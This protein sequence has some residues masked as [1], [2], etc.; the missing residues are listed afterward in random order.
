MTILHDDNIADIKADDTKLK[1]A[2]EVD[3]KKIE[4]ENTDIKDDYDEDDEDIKKLK[5]DNLALKSELKNTVSDLKTSDK[6]ALAKQKLDIDDKL[7]NIDATDRTDSNEIKEIQGVDS[8][9]DK[10]LT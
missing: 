4:D 2:H 8:N 10:E 5:A 3:V 7:I 1:S 6:S 9:H